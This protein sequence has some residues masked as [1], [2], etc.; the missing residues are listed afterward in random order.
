MYHELRCKDFNNIYILLKI[1]RNNNQN[2]VYFKEFIFETNSF[3]NY[4]TLTCPTK[5]K[6]QQI[7]K[8]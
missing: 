6:K 5:R 3:N 2:L 1:C 4:T 8:F 7:F